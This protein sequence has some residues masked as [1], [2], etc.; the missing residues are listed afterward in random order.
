MAP[1][2]N[3]ESPT[4]LL[5]YLRRTG[6]LEATETA[7][8]QV[9]A[10][11]VSNRTVRFQRADG[12]EWVLKQ[13]LAR[14]RVSVEWRCDPARI[15]REALGLRR[16][17]GL[18]PAGTVPKFVFEDEDQYLLAMTAV[19]EPHANWKTEL[20]AGQL[21]PELVR[22]CAVLLGTFHREAAE[23]AAEL[24]AEFAD[25]AFFEALRLEPYF[26]FAAG[27]IPAAARF[28]KKLTAETRGVASTLVHGDFSP[29]NLLVHAGRLVLLDHE[30]IHWGDP[31][32][33]VGFLLTHFLSKAHHL[34]ALRGPFADA[35]RQLWQGYAAE[36]G[37]L[38]GD[39][40]FEPRAV[41]QTMG[42]LLARAAGRSPLE[43]LDA[44][45]R[46]A[47]VKAVTRLCATPPGSIPQLVDEFLSC[48]PSTA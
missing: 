40:A 35:T 9:L 17:A 30:V 48:L 45:E 29:K 20:L 47:Q 6:R 34:P 5:A 14:L 22:Q 8:I 37:P 31:A 21:D 23:R 19:P 41:R 15:Q 44:T 4:E 11:G 33:D 10:G 16:L 39:P 27:R 36:A 46:A 1:E 38:A 43:Y 24:Q 13:A 32:F 3:I 42:C 28:L 18:L 7:E 25:R 26:G 12:V 2:I